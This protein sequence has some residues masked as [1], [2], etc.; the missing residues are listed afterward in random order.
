MAV[1]SLELFDPIAVDVKKT[2]GIVENESYPKYS[3]LEY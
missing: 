1:M 2:S 3:V